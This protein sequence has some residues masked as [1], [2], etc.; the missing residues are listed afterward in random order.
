M[1]RRPWLVLAVAAVAL[2]ACSRAPDDLREWRPS[3]HDHTD[4]PSNN[5]VQSAPDSGRPADTGLA[6]VNEVAIATWKTKCVTCHGMLGR[7]DGP[8]GGMVRARNLADPAWQATVTDAALMA[9]IKN[10]KGEMPAHDLPDETLQGLVKLVRMLAP[11]PRQ[12]SADGGAADAATPA[13][14]HAGVPGAPPIAPSGSA[15]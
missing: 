2:S 14:P 6:G 11:R 3:D 13:N 4:N 1:K 15:P 5:Q 8:R 12:A 10:G 9:S 7:G